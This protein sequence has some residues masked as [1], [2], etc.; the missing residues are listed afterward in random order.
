[1]QRQRHG[2]TK[3]LIEGIIGGSIVGAALTGGV[4]TLLFLVYR[5][6]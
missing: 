6:P 2:T 4:L 5:V 1:M 3:H